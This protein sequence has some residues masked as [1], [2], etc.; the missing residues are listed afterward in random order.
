MGPRG[1]RHHPLQPTALGARP[2]VVH[3]LVRGAILATG[4]PEPAE[5][6]ERTGYDAF[7]KAARRKR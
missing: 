7:D 4:G 2:D 3:I 1:A 5:E 6:L